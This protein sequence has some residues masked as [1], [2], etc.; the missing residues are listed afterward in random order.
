MVGVERKADQRLGPGAPSQL[1]TFSRHPAQ[2]ELSLANP[3]FRQE[4][5]FKFE[6]LNCKLHRILACLYHY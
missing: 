4:N 3:E 2:S 6:G 1:A 5:G